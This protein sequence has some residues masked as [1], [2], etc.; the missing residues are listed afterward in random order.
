MIQTTLF[1]RAIKIT[2]VCL[3]LLHYGAYAA[4]A[5]L[6]LAEDFTDTSLMDSASTTLEWSSGELKLHDLV[7]KRVSFPNSAT[8]G[9]QIGSESDWT[10]GVAYGDV[11]NDGDLDL[12]F[13]NAGQANQLYL[14]DGKGNFSGSAIQI[15]TDSLNSRSLVL[16]DFDK[17]GDLDLAIANYE[18]TNKIYFNDGN[19]NFDAVGTVLGAHS[20]PIVYGDYASMKMIAA[21]ID[22]DGDQDLLVANNG[23]TGNYGEPNR[24]F[25]NDGSGNFSSVATIGTHSDNSTDINL[26]DVDNDG[27]LD[28]IIANYSLSGADKVYYNDGTGSFPSNAAL[29]NST[30]DTYGYAVG[31]IDNDG[32]VDLISASVGTN[33]IYLNDGAGNFTLSTSLS[34]DSLST[35]A[36]SL[37]DIDNDADLDAV[38][39]NYQQSIFYY[40]NDGVGSF[41]DGVQI[42]SDAKATRT[43]LAIDIDTDGDTDLIAANTNGH[44]NALYRNQSA[45]SWPA[46]G[47]ELDSSAAVIAAAITDIDG[48]FFPDVVV[49]QQANGISYYL[50][51]GSGDMSTATQVDNLEPTSLT[52]ADIN[53]DGHKDILAAV[54]GGSNFYYLNSGS[55][56]FNTGQ[57][58]SS[59]LAATQKILVLDIDFDGLNDLITIESGSTNKVYFNLGS[60]NFN[61]A[62]EISSDAQNSRDAV[63]VDLDGDGLKDLVV[64]NYTDVAMVYFN[65]G[66]GAFD[67]TGTSFSSSI[68]AVAVD[69]GDL[70]GDGDF[71]LVIAIESGENYVYVNDGT[72][73]LTEF[74]N[75][76]GS[77]TDSSNDIKLVDIDNDGDLD[78]IIAKDSQNLIFYNDGS[79]NFATETYLNSDVDVSNELAFADFDGNGS[80]DIFV[81]QSSINS[82]IL[83]NNHPGL[84]SADTGTAISADTDNSVGGRV[85]DFNGDGWP[86]LLVANYTAAMKLYLNDS[87]GNLSSVA[88]EIGV[89]TET[90]LVVYIAD[91]DNDGDIDIV[92][93]N[94]DLTKKIYLNDGAAN[95]SVANVGDEVDRTWDLKLVDVDSDGYLDVVSSSA[96]RRLY[97]NNGDGTFPTTGTSI[98]SEAFD[99][100]IVVEDINKD[101]NLDFVVVDS[102]PY[103]YL[104]NGDGT[105]A[106]AVTFG[107]TN[108]SAAYLASGDFNK[109]GYIDLVIAYGT[110]YSGNSIN[111]LYLNDATGSF[112]NPAVQLGDW[113]L[114]TR[115]I[116][117]V[118]L[119]ADGDLDLFFTNYGSSYIVHL[120]DGSGNFDPGRAIEPA[121]FG[122]EASVIADID[123]NGSLEFIELVW[124]G[125]NLVNSISNYATSENIATSIQVN[126]TI[127]EIPQ[128]LLTASFTSVDHIEV[129]FYLSNNG[130]SN[131]YPVENGVP[132]SFANG[133][134]GDLRWKVEYLSRSA[135]ATP[136]ITN[137]V[138]EFVNSLPEVTSVE[139]TDVNEDDAYSYT[140]TATDVDSGDTLSFSASLLPSWLT[141]DTN[142]GV[143]SGT[144]T[145]DNVGDHLVVLDVF[146]GTD[147]QQQSFTITV[148]NTNDAPVITSTAVTTANEDQAYSYTFTATDVDSSDSL[149]LSAPTLPTWLSFDTSTG[150]LSGTASND[151]VGA[152]SVVLAVTDG[153]ETL[154]Q[155][156]TITVANTND[157]PVITSTAVTTATEDQVYSY[158]FSATDVDSSDTLTLSAPTLPTWLNFDASSGIL[159]GTASNDEVG[160]HSVVLAVTDGTES[161]QQS[162][163]I[164]VANTNDAPVITSIAVTTA[165]EDQA[166]SYTFTASDVDSSDTLT[167]SAPTLP[168][169]L[170]FD[171]ST[172][173]L[174]GTAT[175]DE[176][177]SHAVVLAVTDGTETLQQSFIITVAN[178]NDAPVITSTAVTTA[179][180]DQAYS[181]TF[182]ATDVDSSDSLTLSAPTLP[183]W[184]SFDASTG[185]LS[186]TATNDEVG[187]HSVVLAVT[188]GT[189]SLQQSFSITV[190]NTNDAPVITSTAVTT[191]TEDQVYSYTFSATDVDNSDTLILSAPTLP[192]WLSFDA[193]TGALSGTASNDEVGSHSVVLAVTDGTETLQ[194]SFTI[195]VA[196]TND[197][198]VITST[199]V[200]TANEDQVYS[201]TFSASD[202]DSTDTLTLSAPTLPTWLSF[203]TSTGVLSGT[204]SN[205]EVGSHSVVLAVTDGTETLQQ[206]F[207][208]TVANSN[209]APVI[210]STAVT[211]AN[212]DQVYSYTFSATDV[213]SSDTLTLSAPTSP[214]WLSFDANS[215]ILSGT[216]S[217]DEVGSHSVVLAVTDGT[218]TLQQSFTITVANTNDVPVIT[219]TAVTTATEDQAYSYTFSA[220]DVDSSD[221]LTLSA[222]TLPTW[223]SFDANS[224]ILSGTAS[225]D[226]VGSHSVVL[227]VTDGTETLQQSF[228]ITVANTNDAPVITSTAVTTATEDQAYSYT[229]SATDVDNSDTLTLSAPTLPAWLSFDANSGI[230]SG[231]AS[232]D[233][234]GSHSVVLAVSDGTETLQQSFTI[235]VSNTNDAPVITST[236]VTTANEDQVYSYT[237]SA[238][239]VDSSDTLILSA[240]TLP[241]W[242]SFDANSGILSGT[243]SNDEVGS[244][245]VVLAASDGTETLQQSFT[246]TVSNTNDAPVITSTAV[247]TANEDQVYSYTFS[248]SDV[249]SSDTLTLSAPTLPTWLSFDAST[250]VLSGTASNDEVGS[251][252]VVLAV[253]DGT[254][255]LQQSFTITVSN[256]NDAPVITSTAVTTATEDQVYS[257]TFSAN[258]VDSSDTLTLSAPTLPTWLNFDASTGV[259]SGTAS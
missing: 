144:P 123:L 59:D 63:L 29:T 149:T 109:D 49:S 229:F 36:I 80:L 137:L 171:A 120:N 44:A 85:A 22:N 13:A 4:S 182:S 79:A 7:T 164:T 72:G 58:I 154:Q 162:F 10:P 65:T 14:N 25:F 203:D 211:T 169:W 218:E 103:Y 18:Q 134:A 206:S 215:G 135:A 35:Y 200:T 247:T 86:D 46:N 191:A 163:T 31:D 140:L 198:P 30:N 178:T 42:S 189:E 170:S 231:T 102:E 196:N 64:V 160:S 192:T 91:M 50:N 15:A 126:S 188:D 43:L 71:D 17:D 255:T 248:A 145:N 161:L 78:A 129:V 233:E 175:N 176:V 217:N 157:A 60:A 187:S 150:V 153:T 141:F 197:A 21:D 54:D 53:H 114:E 244:H 245:S 220:T 207:I 214:T 16:A 47:T 239:D 143:L 111:L 183:T 28:A 122:A 252:S 34:S 40:L 202:V 185:V 19:G 55:G 230:L 33:N 20:P 174:S 242:L 165:N 9:E 81:A 168:T 238:S 167:L 228:I 39:A 104:G 222:P 38:V 116:E 236:A 115:D 181:Y 256:T 258:D 184:L 225:N 41:A 127:T 205:D 89:S 5:G 108:D 201:Y 221:T 237:F 93:G 12:I 152:H 2:A 70:D 76:F 6:P 37:F 45:G 73:Q 32:D 106:S 56:S 61:N 66:L 74:S 3:C 194:Q 204:A 227:A 234:V 62:E 136:V 226:E 75:A 128:A 193:S 83:F 166:Y 199:A 11:D 250:G 219:S 96:V 98:A 158:T 148:S 208:I 156:F 177:G 223:L 151:E 100:P 112:T 132:L 119:D 110:P 118:D 99:S 190:A 88:T 130:G 117:V 23:L 95:F 27:D 94:Y 124:A 113:D 105:F 246:I 243:A 101:G 173:A 213:D 257:Y 107:Q 82:Q 51:Y 235:T 180:E 240:P 251:H 147:I 68:N 224:G 159:S 24:V 48:D 254:E 121:G 259:L 179:N 139:I 1:N 212:E 77:A 142:S 84:F 26:A 195:T 155:S 138:V 209:D 146:D 133:S 67:S 125:E 90:P 210:T 8:A 97:L 131:W 232:N 57:A 186:G 241:T 52:V 216:A 249:D 172:G 69:Y 92:T 87:F 253:T